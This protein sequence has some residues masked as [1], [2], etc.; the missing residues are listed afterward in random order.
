MIQSKKISQPKI[1]NCPF[2][3]SEA[4]L[5]WVVR[6]Y[7]GGSETI[8]SIDCHNCPSKMEEQLEGGSIVDAEISLANSW[9]KRSIK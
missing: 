9:N 5:D 7:V 8:V 6:D 3:D 2:C 1:S 4:S